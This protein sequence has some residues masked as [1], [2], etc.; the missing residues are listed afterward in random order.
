[1]SRQTEDKMGE[2]AK[3]Y[4]FH[5]DTLPRDDL[6]RRIE[7]LE[8]VINNLLLLQ[9]YTQEDVQKLEGRRTLFVPSGVQIN[10][11]LKQFG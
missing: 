3:W 5:K 4:Y 1:M 8:T 10:G 9:T 7:F 2:L 11:S 6:R